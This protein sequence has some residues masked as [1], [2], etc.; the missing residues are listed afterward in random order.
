MC[1]AL[2]CIACMPRTTDVRKCKTLG[3]I[4][5]YKVISYVWIV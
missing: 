4:Y 1:I 3:T 5:M 2:M